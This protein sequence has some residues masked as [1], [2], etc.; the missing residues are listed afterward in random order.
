MAD[1]PIV[2]LMV[3]D[4]DDP[5][6]DDIFTRC[7]GYNWRAMIAVGLVTSRRDLVTCTGRKNPGQTIDSEASQPLG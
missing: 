4:P 1:Q 5:D 2:H 7:C 6:H 3:V